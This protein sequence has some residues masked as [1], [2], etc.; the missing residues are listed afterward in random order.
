MVAGRQTR[1][2]E[3]GPT[4]RAS[5]L[6]SELAAAL[7]TLAQSSESLVVVEAL[8]SVASSGTD[9]AGALKAGVLEAAEVVLSRLD[10]DRRARRALR[11]VDV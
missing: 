10:V 2:D 9:A 8:R 5:Q 7:G 6:A 1:E 11:F 4:P 3:A